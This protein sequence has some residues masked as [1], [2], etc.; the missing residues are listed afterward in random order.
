[1][2]EILDKV[3]NRGIKKGIEKGIAEGEKK[4]AVAV[5]VTMLKNNESIEKNCVIQRFIA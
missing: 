5:A 1:M 4:R 3:E 2:C